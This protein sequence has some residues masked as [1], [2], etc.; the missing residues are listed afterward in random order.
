VKDAT[1]CR[2]ERVTDSRAC[3]DDPGL[4]VQV[5]RR[6]ESEVIAAGWPVGASLGSEEELRRRHGASR[7]VIREAIRLVEHQRVARMRRGPG[8]GLIVCRPSLEPAAHALAT[9]LH[10]AG[11]SFE[12]LLETRLA[13]GRLA[14]RLTTECIDGPGVERLRR[15]LLADRQLDPGTFWCRPALLSPVAQLSGNRALPLFISVVHRLLTRCL[16]PVRSRLP[17]GDARL[18]AWSQDSRRQ[19]IAAVAAGHAEEAVTLLAERI[20]DSGAWLRAHGADP[21][22]IGVAQSVEN[23]LAGRTAERIKHDIATDG[24]RIGTLL[25]TERELATRYSVGRDVA[26]ETIRILVYDGVAEGRRGRS[27]GVAVAAPRADRAVTSIAANLVLRGATRDDLYPVGAA[28]QSADNPLIDVFE[29]IIAEACSTVVT[30][31]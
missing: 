28:L 23:A 2:I 25:G 11:T 31:T 26:R 24:W 21:G 20:G 18:E 9:Y 17:G 22:V 12:D 7:A 27:G 1:S 15:D 16:T 30:S 4:A 3:T 6:I 29:S 8:G 14:F 10:Y 13:L 19:I 5:V